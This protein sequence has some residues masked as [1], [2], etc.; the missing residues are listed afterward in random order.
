M[1][2][3]QQSQSNRKGSFFIEV[4]RMIP[5]TVKVA[6]VDYVVEY[7][8]FIEING[9]RNYQGACWYG[10]SKIEI[11]NDL[12][13]TKKQQVFVHELVHAIFNEAGFDEQDEDT[14]NR[15]GIV[16]HQV[17]RDNKIQFD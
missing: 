14:V 10:E 9:N 15:I 8:D 11:M 7:K 2:S 16:L 6:G 1:C 17:L 4:K 13:E 3:Y 12:S 5:I